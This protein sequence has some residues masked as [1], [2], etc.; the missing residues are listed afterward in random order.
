MDKIS[1]IVPVYNGEKYLNRCIDSLLNQSYRNNE[2]I[3]I[4]D[5]S[6][7]D[8]LEILNNY[9]KKDERITVIDKKNTG[10]SD[11][12]NI[13]I[14]NASGNYICFCDADDIYDKNYIEI[15]HSLAIKNNASVVKCNFRV[16]DKSGKQIDRGKDFFSNKKFNNEN[17]ISDII[18][19]CL[20]GDIP[21]F[22]YLLMIKKD[23]LNI[24]FPTD[25]AMMEDVV[26][27]I[28]LLLNIDSLFIT[29]E[30]L[31][32]IMFNNEGATNNV[33]NYKRNISNV[34]LVNRYI[35]NILS[36]NNLLSSGNSEK[37]NINHLNSIADFIFK[38]Y[39][40][41]NDVINFCKEIRTLDFISLIDDTNLSKI[42]LVRR[43]PLKLI[44]NKHYFLLRIYFVLR[45]IVFDFKRR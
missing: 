41:G 27:Y 11:S 43:I 25:I 1:V 22:T 33:K 39:L 24:K 4:N 36:E 30:Q 45:K 17:I 7:D 16:V 8:T 15:M 18:P 44:R 21:C 9:A 35:H 37:L 31:Y 2:Y 26:F 40:Y 20:G 29:G 10:V 6:T 13:G 19:L 3:F 38:Y 23:V 5:G 42:N 12:R 34:I 32:T 28:D 14:G